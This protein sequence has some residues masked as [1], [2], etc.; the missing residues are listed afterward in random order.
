MSSV[1][2]QELAI[3]SAKPVNKGE[4]GIQMIRYTPF[5]PKQTYFTSDSIEFNIPASST[6][7]VDLAKSEL[8]MK[9]RFWKDK[10]R[11][12]PFNFD[13]N[14]PLAAD[15]EITFP[16]DAVFHTMWKTI[17]LSLNH[18]DI[19]SCTNNY[20]YKAYLETLFSFG[21]QCKN[22][23]LHCAGYTGNDSDFN[24]TN[25]YAS[26]NGGANRRHNMLIKDKALN[27]KEGGLELTGYLMLD[28]CNQKTAI[29]NGVD[30]NL[31]FWPNNDEFILMTYPHTLKCHVE[32]E[33]IYLDVYKS[34]L[35]PEVTIGH[36]RS[37]ANKPAIYEFQ[38]SEINIFNIPS[39][40]YNWNKDNIFANRTPSRVVIGFVRSD[41]YIGSSQLNPLK[42]G[43]YGIDTVALYWNG[44]P[45]RKQYKIDV[46][47]AIYLDTYMGMYRML[48]KMWD[49]SDIPI[50]REQFKNGLTLFCFTVDPTSAPDLSYLGTKTTGTTSIN[51]DFKTNKPTP[52]PLTVIVY[53]TFPGTISI[54]E[55]RVVRDLSNARY[56]VNGAKYLQSFLQNKSSN[57][58]L[59]GTTAAAA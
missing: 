51:V 8:F 25:P 56:Q 16:I 47:N 12:V 43:H 18:T 33:E 13:E 7:Y 44:L 4:D 23:Q 24:T 11:T 19:S 31:T 53:G 55:A 50:S 48:G 28:I 21:E 46:D 40:Q 2:T 34:I 14:S 3:Y 37:L 20:M 17:D 22:N 59:V 9:L 15:S 32:I 49:D 38:K 29:L 41:A 36:D 54:D 27:S 6:Q 5:N 35:N 52:Y 30:I 10:E 45:V 57:I 1:H 58:D 26:F 42:F 39:G